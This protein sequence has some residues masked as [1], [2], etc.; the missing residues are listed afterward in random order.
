MRNGKRRMR[1]GRRLGQ[2]RPTPESEDRGRLFTT[3]REEVAEFARMGGHRQCG[4][5]G[6]EWVDKEL[7]V[8]I[9]IQVI[10]LSYTHKGT[11]NHN[12][13]VIV[14]SLSLTAPTVCAEGGWP[15]VRL[16]LPGRTTSHRYQP[17]L[18]VGLRGDCGRTFIK[19]S[20]MLQHPGSVLPMYNA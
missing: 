6:R 9:I 13:L 18:A 8:S 17:T 4:E 14:A 5:G 10:A 11:L 2:R 20:D 3:A 1:A 7:A 19:A 15:L 16:G 12:V